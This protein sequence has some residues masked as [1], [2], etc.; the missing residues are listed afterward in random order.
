[1]INCTEVKPNQFFTWENE[2]YQCIETTL[3]K[4]A[5]AK[6]KVK[7]KV[8]Q[9]RNGV[10]KELSLISGDKVNEATVDRKNMLFLYDAG[11]DMVFMDSDTFD[12][13][14]IPKTRL[15]WESNFLTPNLNVAIT[16]YEGEV[17]GV[18]LPDKVAL[19]VSEAENAV[20]GDTATAALKNAVL[21]TGLNVKVPLF[22]ETDESIVVSTIDGKYAGR[23]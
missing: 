22:I 2:L 14:E 15:E 1:M 4:T 23:A 11:D 12:Q 21:E 3:N 10:I 5:M 6:M 18:I 20:R 19:K 9:P 7:I 13:I 16:V 17:L 8:K